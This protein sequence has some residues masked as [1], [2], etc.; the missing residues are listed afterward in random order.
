MEDSLAGAKLASWTT[1]NESTI[2]ESNFLDE[3]GVMKAWTSEGMEQVGTEM[4]TCISRYGLK[5]QI[6]T[7]DQAPLQ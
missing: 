7:T 6:F 4:R 2:P 5:K 3:D 1:L